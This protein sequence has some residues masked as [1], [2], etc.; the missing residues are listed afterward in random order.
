MERQADGQGEQ[1]GLWQ[2]AGLLSVLPVLG[3]EG[4]WRKMTHCLAHPAS[5][6]E[7]WNDAS[8]CTPRMTYR[9][10]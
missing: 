5:E 3:G 8:G 7:Q 10:A 9:K 1:W 6:P 4:F 2:D